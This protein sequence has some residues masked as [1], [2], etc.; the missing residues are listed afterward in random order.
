M[1]G[2]LTIGI[3]T[4]KQRAGASSK[5]LRRLYVQNTTDNTRAKKLIILSGFECTKDVFIHSSKGARIQTE[6]SRTRVSLFLEPN[7]RH[8][9]ISHTLYVLVR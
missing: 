1:N 7:F 6:R 5:Y 3:K 8:V 4:I 2:T 9:V